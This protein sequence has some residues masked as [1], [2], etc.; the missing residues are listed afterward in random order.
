MED[1]RVEQRLLADVPPEGGATPPV[2][3]EAAP[4]PAVRD[5]VPPR[6]SRRLAAPDVSGGFAVRV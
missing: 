4:L 5:R 3:R 1:Q 6:R 2:D